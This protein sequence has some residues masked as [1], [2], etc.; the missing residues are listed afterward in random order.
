MKEH[1]WEKF[2]NLW[3]IFQNVGFEYKLDVNQHFGILFLIFGVI[4]MILDRF[5]LNEPVQFGHSVLQIVNK[6]HHLVKFT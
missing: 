1:Q 3:I 6:R 5:K 4:F 2:Y